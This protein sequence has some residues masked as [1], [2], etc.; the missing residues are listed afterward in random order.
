[1]MT[2]LLTA[3]DLASTAANPLIVTEK[4]GCPTKLLSTQ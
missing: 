1:M 2:G 3:E 4:P